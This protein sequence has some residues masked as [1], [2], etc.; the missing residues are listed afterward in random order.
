MCDV[1]C[2]DSPQKP[3]AFF[4]VLTNYPVAVLAG[5]YRDRSFE[6][7][8]KRYEAA[9]GRL[10]RIAPDMLPPFRGDLP[11]EVFSGRR[12]FPALDSFFAGV[13]DEFFPIKVQGDVLWGLNKT[14][15][16]WWVWCLN[17]KGVTKFADAFEEI[18]E[19]AASR[20]RVELGVAASAHVRELI[21]ERDVT[22]RGGGFDW[23]VPAG[24]VAVFE[25][26]DCSVL[27]RKNGS[28]DF[29]VDHGTHRNAPLCG[30][31]RAEKKGFHALQPQ[32]AP[33]KY[34]HMEDGRMSAR[35]PKGSFELPSVSRECGFLCVQ[36]LNK[37]GSPH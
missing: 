22:V 7:V 15:G 13:R 37:I 6:T 31:E 16:G 11:G 19:S 33:S 25:V 17:N 18:D 26:A 9:G 36:W 12:R 35:C 24:G 21:S 2:P 8:L 28:S 4:S 23:I 5:E 3:E 30:T 14:D 32:I 10:L 20:I 29:L 34:Q 1:L 27:K